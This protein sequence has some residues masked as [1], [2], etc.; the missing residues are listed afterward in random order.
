V[1]LEAELLGAT[2]ADPSQ[3]GHQNVQPWRLVQIYRPG[4][5][6]EAAAH[7]LRALAPAAM[8][9]IEWVP[10]VAGRRSLAQILEATRPTDVLVL[11][12]RP[13]D[14]VALGNSPP[15]VAQIFVSGQLGGFEHAALPAS[16]RRGRAISSMTSSAISSSS[17]S[18]PCSAALFF[19]D[20]TRD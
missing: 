13:A 7:A 8:E 15:Q 2:L 4:E 18:S 5:A 11:W 6:G 17:V 16:W 19:P 14:L 10:D 20:T 12:L 9:R 3:I 1:L